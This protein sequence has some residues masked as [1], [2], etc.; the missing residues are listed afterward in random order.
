MRIIKKNISQN[1]TPVYVVT[2]GGRRVEEQNYHAESPAIARAYKLIDMVATY[3]PHEKNTI[4]V[5]HTSQ[6]EKVR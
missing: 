4:H 2:R 1:T 6:P 5:L 3:S